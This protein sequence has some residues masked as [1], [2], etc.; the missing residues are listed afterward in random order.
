MILKV[1]SKKIP[2]TGYAQASARFVFI[3]HA[4]DIKTGRIIRGAEVL[5]DGGEF[6]AR[7]SQNG[8]VW[9]GREYVPGETAIYSPE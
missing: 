2:V 3:K 8:R 6:I 1:G 9:A 5:T 4:E 7:I